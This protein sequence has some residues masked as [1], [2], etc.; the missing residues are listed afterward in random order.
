MKLSILIPTIP[1]RRTGLLLLMRT[2]A[3]QIGM[4]PILTGM[5]PTPS[6]ERRRFSVGSEV[7]IIT[8]EDNATVD[9]GV[10]R[11][12]LLGSAQGDFIV[13]FDDD[14]EPHPR[15]L[16][17]ILEAIAPGVDCIGYKVACYGYAN[18][19]N[20]PEIMEPADVSIKY[21]AWAN[22]VGGFKYVRTPHHIMPVRRTHAL[23]AGFPAIH[24][25]EDHAY[26]MRLKQQGNL[27][28]EVYIDEFLYIYRFNGKKKRGE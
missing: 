12:A 16:P 6:G 19:G 14:D 20:S 5:E 17:L 4:V 10:K 26:S 18:G 22:D 9:V 27:K 7:E 2:L 23:A 28:N 24:H 1:A 3:Q 8:L 11:Q 15:Y 25:G 13:F 21:D